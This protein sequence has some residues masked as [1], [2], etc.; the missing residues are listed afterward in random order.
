ML[1]KPYSYTERYGM[2]LQR[3]TLDGGFLRPSRTPR[4]DCSATK[5]LSGDSPSGWRK[6]HLR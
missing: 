2:R 5:S 6:W 3:L 4:G 1:F